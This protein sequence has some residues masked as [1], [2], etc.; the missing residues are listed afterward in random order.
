MLIRL[1]NVRSSTVIIF[2][3]DVA[4]VCCRNMTIDDYKKYY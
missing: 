1:N 3:M 2:A 4:Y